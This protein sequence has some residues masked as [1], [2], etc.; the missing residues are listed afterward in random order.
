MCKLILPLFVLQM[1]TLALLGQNQFVKKPEKDFSKIS[2]PC[3]PFDETYKVNPPFGSGSRTLKICIKQCPIN[4]TTPPELIVFYSRTASQLTNVS[5]NPSAA[6]GHGKAKFIKAVGGVQTYEY[7]F[8]HSGFTDLNGTNAEFKIIEMPSRG[9]DKNS[10]VIHYRLAVK[11]VGMTTLTI[12]P[13]TESFP[14]PDPIT[15]GIV[16]DSFVA[17]EGA[18]L[19]SDRTSNGNKALMWNDQDPETSSD[20]PCH[21]SLNS[22]HAQAVAQIKLNNKKIA[23]QAKFVACSGAQTGDLMSVRQNANGTSVPVQFNMLED[24]LASKGYSKLDLLLLGIGGNDVGFA[25]LIFDYHV[26]P[27]R[28]FNNDTDAKNR[29]T[30]PNAFGYPW[31]VLAQNYDALK[32]NIGTRFS[33]LDFNVIMTGGPSPCTGPV[34]NPW[35]G[36]EN[37]LNP[38]N[39][40]PGDC[41]GLVEVDDRPAEWRDLHTLVATK[42]NTTMSEAAARNKWTFVP[43]LDRAGIHGLSNCAAPYFNT[44]GR[45]MSHQGDVSG[46]VH[47]NATGYIQMYKAPIVNALQGRINAINSFWEDFTSDCASDAKAAAIAAA[48]ERAK[49]KMLANSSTAKL[50]PYTQTYEQFRSAK[51]GAARKDALLDYTSKIK[52][53]TIKLPAPNLELDIQDQLKNIDF[54]D[55]FN[56]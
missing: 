54:M 15:I 51:F 21:R 49:A 8:P 20:V 6:Y 17:G 5:I 43:M 12:N 38:S 56:K 42:L 39:N 4:S 25:D 52:A 28:D 37:D 18:P 31:T 14:M 9:N 47:P 13:S 36:E 23:I 53:G 29:F 46:T 45:S 48:K 11:P 32:A 3:N 1:M 10:A 30:S 7:V 50:M 33:I 55:K 26:V 34:G 35:C 2:L 19:V 22:G 44:I 40:V 41:W 27:F 16:G 24:W